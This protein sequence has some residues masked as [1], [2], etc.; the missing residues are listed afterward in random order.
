MATGR[1]VIAKTAALVIP[2]PAL[3]PVIPAQAGA[4]MTKK[5]GAFA[6]L[7]N[8]GFPRQRRENDDCFIEMRFRVLSIPANSFRCGQ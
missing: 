8:V 5:N 6:P 4:G 1:G 3:L 2:A 7:I